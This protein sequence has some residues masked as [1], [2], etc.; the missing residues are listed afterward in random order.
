MGILSSIFNIYTG[1]KQG[2]EANQIN[3]VYT[4]F[5]KSPYAADTLGTAQQLFGGR[6]AGA[7][8][9]EQNI[10]G[11]TANT[12]AQ[13]QKT[14]TDPAQALAIESATQAQ[15]GQQF[16]NL[17]TT[18]DQNKYQLLNNL[19]LANA[20]ETSENDKSY[21]AMLQKYMLDTQQ[22]S[23]LRGASGKN[24]AS[25]IG[26][27][28]SAATAGNAASGGGAGSFLGPVLSALI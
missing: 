12:D 27:I 15:A 6:M 24:I 2:S 16:R 5:Q 18:E 4:P 22:Q 26:G 11:N 23:A 14:A 3:P 10:Y 17:A 21:Q 7:T 25:G 19:N 13:I 20:G 9:L 1:V 28:E 8:A